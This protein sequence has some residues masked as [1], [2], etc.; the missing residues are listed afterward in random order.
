MGIF[1]AKKPSGPKVTVRPAIMI[2]PSTDPFPLVTP[3]QD[4]PQSTPYPL[5]Q[6]G[7]RFYYYAEVLKPSPRCHSPPNDAFQRFPIRSSRLLANGL[8]HFFKLFVRGQ[9]VPPSK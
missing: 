2:I 7:R 3:T 8:F 4:A 9:R 1:K 6:A 5:I